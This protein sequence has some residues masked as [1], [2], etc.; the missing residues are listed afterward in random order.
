MLIVKIHGGLGN[1]LF[2]YAFAKSLAC[3]NNTDFKL[4]IHFFDNQ[5]LRSYNLC[6]FNVIE[7]IASLNEISVFKQTKS[8]AFNFLKSKLFNTEAHIVEEKSLEF[9][10][11]YFTRST[12]A[13]LSGYWQSEKYFSDIKTQIQKE[14]T[15]KTAPSA[16][17]C[18]LLDKI[19]S[20]N[21]ISLHIRRGDFE[22]DKAVNKIHGTCSLAYYQNAADLVANKLIDPI[23][24]I[25]SDD[26]N[27]A[28]YNLK[29][30][31]K[32][33]FVDINDEHSAFEDLRL[34]YNCKHHIIANSTFSW[35]G[36]WLN[37]K[38]D[39][40]VVAPVNWFN[41]AGLNYQA[42]DIVPETWIR[43]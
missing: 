9:N 15:P 32:L 38:P 40:I 12:N 30:N 3:K 14:F 27:W 17:N 36:A 13:Y 8:S 11:V 5:A 41:D 10:S 34:M 21:A 16:T 1:Q 28:R 19:K 2:Q 39:K 24:F 4:D 29:L 35:W 31:Y 26:I 18:A 33:H 42:K 25:F 23:F 20:N 7:N 37:T 22:M 6:N 43:I